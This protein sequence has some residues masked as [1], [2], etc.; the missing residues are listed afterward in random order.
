M[1]TLASQLVVLLPQEARDE[2]QKCGRKTPYRT[3]G[4]ATAMALRRHQTGGLEL[5]A[6]PCPY[7]KTHFHLSHVHPTPAQLEAMSTFGAKQVR[8]VE[9]ELRQLRRTI[10][11]LEVKVRA[12]RLQ[13][14]CK[15]EASWSGAPF[16][17]R[18]KAHYDALR[19][20]LADVC[21]YRGKYLG[22]VYAHDAR[23]TVMSSCQGFDAPGSA[24]RAAAEEQLAELTSSLDALADT[25][26]QM[27]ADELKELDEREAL[28]LAECREVLNRGNRRDG[29]MRC[30]EDRDLL[31]TW[32][33]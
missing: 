5:Y 32:I 17:S 18:I 19:Q 27:Y 22:A 15:L 13:F 21:Q 2:Y 1:Q 20:L 28:D 33:F 11:D 16:P 9:L 6:Y 14:K 24:W 31:K 10:R 29:A 25:A 7:D 23:L 3:L 30:N 4:D 26:A 12:T 8:R